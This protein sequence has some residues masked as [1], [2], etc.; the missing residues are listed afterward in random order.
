MPANAPLGRGQVVVDWVHSNAPKVMMVLRVDEAVLDEIVRFYTIR[1][2][3]NRSLL[4]VA[5]LIERY[6][7]L[8][9]VLW[10]ARDALRRIFPDSSYALGVTRDPDIDDEQLVLSIGVGRDPAKSR[11]DVKRLLLLQDEWGLDADRRAE[12]KLAVVLA[13]L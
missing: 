11:D 3:N 1:D 8:V 2:G 6:P 4:K 13:T 9:D 5:R 10:D 7:A 12:G